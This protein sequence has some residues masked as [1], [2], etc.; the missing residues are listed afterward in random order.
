LVISSKLVLILHC[1]FS[2]IGPYITQ[3]PKCSQFA[4]GYIN[5]PHKTSVCISS[6][7]IYIYIH[8]H[9]P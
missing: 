2:F 3:V 8:I 9:L 5:I 7:Y 4:T 1:P 6:P